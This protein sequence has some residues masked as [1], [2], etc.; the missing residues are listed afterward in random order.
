ML[1]DNSALREVHAE[2]VDHYGPVPEAVDNLFEVAQFRQHARRAGLSD[3]TAQGK[4]VRFA[5]VELPESAQLR[6]KRLYPGTVLKPALRTVLV[7]LPTT[8]RIG[9]K[10][11]HGREVLTWCRQLIDAVMLNDV[12]AAAQ[13]GTT[14]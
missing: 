4:F 6:L 10:P 9:G 5:P 13:V 12:S 11:L 8:A 14:R 7:P 2:L 3:I 1:T